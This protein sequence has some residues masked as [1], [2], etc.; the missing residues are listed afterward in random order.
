ML[1]GRWMSLL[2]LSALGLACTNAAQAQTLGEIQTTPHVCDVFRVLAGSIM[3]SRQND[4]SKASLLAV[5]SGNPDHDKLGAM[6]INDAYSLPVRGSQ[7]Q[8]NEA[9]N[10]FADKWRDTCNKPV[11][12]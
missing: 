5:K 1:K 11:S 4:E 7:E 3:Q 12:G 2:V 10:A 8:K 9:I 6:L